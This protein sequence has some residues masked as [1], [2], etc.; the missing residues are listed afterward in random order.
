MKK[1][2]VPSKQTQEDDEKCGQTD[3]SYSTYELFVIYSN[4]LDVISLLTNVESSIPSELFR[5]CA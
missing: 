2:E 4:S 1:E 3:N 5:D